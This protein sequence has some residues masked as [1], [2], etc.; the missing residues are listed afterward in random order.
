M[1]HAIRPASAV[2][3]ADARFKFFTETVLPNIEKSKLTHVLVFIPSYFDFV[4]VRNHLREQESDFA[5]ICEY[6]ERPNVS[7]ARSAFFHGTR[8]VLLYTERFHF[9]NRPSLR[10]IKHVVFY[11][12]PTYA[13]FYPELLNR[14]T[15]PEG[16]SCSVLY[17]RYDAMQLAAVIGAKR[18]KKLLASSKDSHM[19]V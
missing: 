15:Q 9:H 13:D 6:T 4:R 10:N 14:I 12:L 2:D 17:S 3:D 7:R 5:Q 16:A 8:P 19:F 18:S 11:Q 1:Y